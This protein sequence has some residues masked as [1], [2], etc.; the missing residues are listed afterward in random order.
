ML[1]NTQT[2]LIKWGDCDPAGIVFYPRYFAWF[3][4]ATAALFAAAGLP[5]HKLFPD[6]GIAGMPMVDTRARFIVPS[7]F[8]DEVRIETTI[9]EF[10]RSSFDVR[11]QLFRGDTLSVEGFETRV[12]T[13]WDPEKP[14]RIKAQII[15]PEVIALFNAV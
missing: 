7:K 1:T 13:I 12:W 15:P 6:F 8:G 5:I 9:T 14:E 4:A 11:H 2:K 3:D 10:R